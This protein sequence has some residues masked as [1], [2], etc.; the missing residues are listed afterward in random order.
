M[1]FYTAGVSDDA[2]IYIYVPLR[3][4]EELSYI[5][6]IDA[7]LQVRDREDL[8]LRMPSGTFSVRKLTPPLQL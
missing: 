5:V 2:L 8:Q 1:T 3:L 6:K 7:T 4:T